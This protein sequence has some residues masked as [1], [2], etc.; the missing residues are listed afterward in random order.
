MTSD[1]VRRSML[2]ALSWRV[3]ATFV[4]M[5]VAHAVTKQLRFAATVGV[6]DAIIK[7]GAYYAHER[8]WNRARPAQAEPTN[9][10]I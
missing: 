7:L 3:I 4:T 5:A 6:A 1:T 10:T 9:D 8:L 2:K